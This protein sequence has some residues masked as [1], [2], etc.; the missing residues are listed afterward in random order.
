MSKLL[1]ASSWI[2]QLFLE[3][4]QQLSPLPYGLD[5]DHVT[6][7]CLMGGFVLLAFLVI[8]I[9]AQLFDTRLIAGASVWSK[10]I[11]FSFSLALHFISIAVLAQLIHKDYR[12]NKTVTAFAYAGVGAALFELVY[13]TI[14][15]GRGRASHF[16]FETAT[17][18]FMYSMMGVGALFLV[19]ISFVVGIMILRFNTFKVES[20]KAFISAQGQ[21]DQL[22]SKMA[23][24]IKSTPVDLSLGLRWGAVLGLVIGSLLT[25]IFAGYMSSNGSAL[26]GHSTE[27]ITMPIFGWSLSKG[28]LR[29]PHFIA[30]H[31]IQLLPI[32]GFVCDKLKLPSTS[33]KKIVISSTVLLVSLTVGIFILMLKGFSVMA[34]I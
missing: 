13:I 20:K 23:S 3:P 28:D 32:I 16:N 30:T 14:Q 29:I 15:A 8:L 11:K 6:R 4:K 10:P 21:T 19:A 1:I 5:G 22:D 9:P 26:V 18:I 17:E 33:I 27:N 25:L 7:L 24:V 2:K 31:I 12:A 34:V